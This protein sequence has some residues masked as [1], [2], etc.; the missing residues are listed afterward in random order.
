M[1]SFSCMK[2]PMDSQWHRGPSTRHFNPRPLAQVG[3]TMSR[4]LTA[5]GLSAKTR[6]A[7][8]T[9]LRAA[10]RTGQ[11]KGK[12]E[13]RPAS[14]HG[15]ENHEPTCSRIP[16]GRRASEMGSRWVQAI[17]PIRR[18]ARNLPD[19]PAIQRRTLPPMRMLHAAQDPAFNRSLPAAQMVTGCV[20]T[21]AG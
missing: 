8:N 13:L 5:K 3:T 4:F 9:H 12:L 21:Q 16:T 15:I 6:R 1:C 2:T 14:F 11:P 20:D 7:S 17:R 10:T 19:L 18:E